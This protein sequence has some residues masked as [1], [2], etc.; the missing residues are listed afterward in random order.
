MP[1][2]VG[3]RLA[4][5]EFIDEI[6]CRS[7]LSGGPKGGGYWATEPSPTD[8]QA[9]LSAGNFRAG[10]EAL[11]KEHPGRELVLL[12]DVGPGVVSGV[13]GSDRAHASGECGAMSSPRFPEKMGFNNV[14]VQHGLA[15]LRADLEKALA[16]LDGA[17]GPVA[18]PAPQ[19]E[20]GLEDGPGADRGPALPGNV[21]TGFGRPPISRGGVN[22]RWSG[23]R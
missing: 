22:S 16:S 1:V 14:H 17:G 9:A 4:T 13:R 6:G 10:V 23:L 15:V 3:G 8:G 20:N 19:P 12:V 11:R 5:L 2:K 7:V 18:A 21:R